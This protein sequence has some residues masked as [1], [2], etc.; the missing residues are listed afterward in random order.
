[1]LAFPSESLP[2]PQRHCVE[3]LPSLLHWPLQ[4]SMPDLQNAPALAQ[5]P[6][7]PPVGFAAHLPNTQ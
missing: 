1:M 7:P 4:Q 5:F 6:P 3:P 2:E